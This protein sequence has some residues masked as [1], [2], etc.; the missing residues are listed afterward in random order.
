MTWLVKARTRRSAGLR[1]RDRHIS[2]G[3][4]P[5]NSH[6]PGTWTRQNP[7]HSERPTSSLTVRRRSCRGVQDR[8]LRISEPHWV[9]WGL[10]CALE[11]HQRWAAGS[12]APYRRARL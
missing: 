8:L 11:P 12:G 2:A 9:P 5:L 1:E 10:R 3:I 7:R 6:I 4:A